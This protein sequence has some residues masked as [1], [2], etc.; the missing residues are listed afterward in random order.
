M[1]IRRL[2]LDK[3]SHYKHS[4]LCESSLSH[5]N[6][7]IAYVRM[8][9]CL[10]FTSF[11]FLYQCYHY[12]PQFPDYP[13]NWVKNWKTEKVVE[14]FLFPLHSFCSTLHSS[15]PFLL[16]LAP[17][18][19]NTCSLSRWST[20]SCHLLQRCLPLR[21]WWPCQRQEHH[22]N[23]LPHV[24]DTCLWRGRKSQKTKLLII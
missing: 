3:V 23:L 24:S 14:V 4:S 17:F 15:F 21:W 9:V 8:H 1:V 13:S 7:P 10:G 16:P 19:L 22:L 12:P 6:W 11:S 2:Q 20:P 5:Q 18:L